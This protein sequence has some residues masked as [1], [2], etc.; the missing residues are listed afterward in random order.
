MATGQTFYGYDNPIALP[1]LIGDLA[2]DR[3][4]VSALATVPLFPGLLVRVVAGSNT[5]PPSVEL[6]LDDTGVILGVVAYEDTKQGSAPQG[7]YT[8]PVGDVARVMRK[9]RIWAYFVSG[10]GTPAQYAA[11]RVVTTNAASKQG[12]LTYAAVA[13]N[14]VRDLTGLAQFTRTP[15][16]SNIVG[17]TGQYSLA[18]ISCNFDL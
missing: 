9:G 16:L 14:A 10:S 6:P 13:A 12:Q 5:V 3:E 8:I 7:S 1:G 17:G 11:A 2:T 4:V 15:S 18:Q